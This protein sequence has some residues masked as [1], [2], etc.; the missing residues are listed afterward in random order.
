MIKGGE[1]M[2]YPKPVMRMSELKKMGFPEEYLKRVY[3]MQKQR[4]AWKMNPL[5][6]TSPIVFDTEELEKFRIAE[7]KMQ[8]TSMPKNA[9]VGKW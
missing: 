3:R 7:I 9:E 8:V 1:A 6:N 5:K 4:I 2:Q